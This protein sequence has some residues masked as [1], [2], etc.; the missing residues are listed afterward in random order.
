M[1]LTDSG[2]VAIGTSP[3]AEACCEDECPAE[4][5]CIV[6]SGSST[7][8]KEWTHDV[9]AY[10]GQAYG[11]VDC[12]PVNKMYGSTIRITGY[13][14]ATTRT[15]YTSG[16]LAGTTTY[17][18]SEFTFNDTTVQT[19]HRCGPGTG[20]IGGPTL[21]GTYGVVGTVRY[22]TDLSSWVGPLDVY[23]VIE[24]PGMVNSMTASN[25]V[26]LAI[27][28]YSGAIANLSVGALIPW[29][30]AYD[31]LPSPRCNFSSGLNSTQPWTTFST[32]VNSSDLTTAS[33]RIIG[34]NVPTGAFVSGGTAY[35]DD[36]DIDV[37][38]VLG[39]P[40]Y[41]CD[42]GALLSQALAR[43]RASDPSIPDTVN[44][45]SVDPT[46]L[47]RVMEQQRSMGISCCGG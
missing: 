19:Y 24:I 43:V 17:R 37:E 35:A 5:C 8:Y 45:R 34:D 33:W 46:V 20:V 36:V 15:V 38:Y 25:R 31:A 30:N 4:A 9:S 21:E 27:R 12:N 26:Q 16:P 1:R 23:A 41:P 39:E 40:L 13:A 11:D 42:Y 14:Y 28:P 22:T 29:S 32:T 18:R 6:T 2:H 3:C 7:I 47:A 10:A 44:V